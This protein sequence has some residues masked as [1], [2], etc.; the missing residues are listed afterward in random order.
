MNCGVPA[1]LIC[2]NAEALVMVA[3]ALQGSVATSAKRHTHP[4]SNI[5]LSER[6]NMACFMTLAHMSSRLSHP[7]DVFI[8]LT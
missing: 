6:L 7:K 2:L 8:S 4:A 1:E 3:C 5:S